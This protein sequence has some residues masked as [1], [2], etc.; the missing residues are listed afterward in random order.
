MPISEILE[1]LHFLPQ[2]LAGHIFLSFM[3][4]LIGGAIS[5]PLGVWCSRRKQAERIAL[6]VASIIQTIPSLALLAAMVFAWGKI[7]WFPA[8]VALVLYSLL[9]MLRNTITGIQSVDAACLEAAQGLGMN[10]RQR[11]RLVELPLAAP[12]IVA[13]VR[14]AAV[15]VVGAATIAQPVGATSLGNYIFA[16]LQ[17]LNPVALGVGCFFS[18]ALALSIDALLGM[19]E[20]AVQTRS[21]KMGL[22]AALGIV[23][24]ILSPFLI[25]L[26]P[27][28][29]TNYTSHG[30]RDLATA[31]QF[32]DRTYI[33]GGKGFT[34][35]RILALVIQEELQQV[36]RKVELKEGI[37][38]AVIFRALETGQIDCYVDYSGTLWANVLGREEFVSSP[39]MLID[40]ATE[41]KAD[42][43]V[44]S[45]GTL[46]FRN[47]YVFVMKQEKA[48][49]LGIKT[50][51]DLAK[52]AD[53]LNAVTDIEFWERPEWARVRDIYQFDFKKKQSMDA[54][55][56]YGAIANDKADVVVA[57]RT[58]GRI[59]AGGLVEIADPARAL[60]PYDA[61]LLASKRLV[62]DPVAVDQLLK[63]IN[64]ISTDEMRDANRAVDTDGSPVSAAAKRIMPKK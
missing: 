53:K 63:M 62:E 3:A 61:I 59:A 45:L 41:L 48:A 22:G 1:Q 57:F 9:P 10:D 2:R 54:T 33:I 37:G 23:A 28:G 32:D 12:T 17:T 7:G 52:H 50:L 21:R 27:L 55:L 19:L 38:S 42:H 39:E 20:I 6:T 5:L 60:P 40:L 26:L 56:M 16:G 8:L 4:L 34:E 24:I 35:Q 25:S 47:D 51:D 31:S 44:Y 11:L 18:A 43:Q 30:D 46:G 49:E 13:G 29:Q 36:G 14:T 15:W 58:D 64:S